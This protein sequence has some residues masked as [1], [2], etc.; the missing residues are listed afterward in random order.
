ML[1]PWG[2]MHTHAVQHS[3]HCIYQVTAVFWELPSSNSLFTQINALWTCSSQEASEMYQKQTLS[4]LIKIYGLGL[5]HK[6][7]RWKMLEDIQP[8][9]VP[10]EILTCRRP[11]WNASAPSIWNKILMM[12]IRSDFTFSSQFTFRWN[13][14]EEILLA[15]G[16]YVSSFGGDLKL[17]EVFNPSND[18]SC[19]PSLPF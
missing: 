5:C 18:W 19:T 6:T 1:W 9:L 3:K 8:C 16:N 17:Y 12:C 14:K 15:A 11:P 7:K 2:E 13:V 4:S 10:G